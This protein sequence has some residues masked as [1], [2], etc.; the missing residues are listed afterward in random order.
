MKIAVTTASGGLGKTVIKEL[1]KKYKPEQIIGLAR[2]PEKARDL[3]I[4]IKPGDYNQRSDF[5]QGLKNVNTVLLVSA[6][7]PPDK[8]INM[9]RNVIEG[10][11]IAGVNKIIY[12]SIFGEAGKCSFDA[13]I[14]SNRQTENDIQTSGLKWIIGRNGLYIDADLVSVPEYKKTGKITNSA[15]SGKCSYTSRQ[16][17]AVAYTNLMTNDSFN[18]N[19]YNLC[20]NSITQEE[21]AQVFNQIFNL[22]LKYEPVSIESYFEDRIQEHG[23]FLGR[24]IGGIYQGIRLGVFDVPSDFEEIC[25]RKHLTILEMVKN[26][27]KY[28]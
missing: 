14:H 16:E 7:G 8:R 19:I 6:N 27:E 25:G 1:L 26:Y 10:A 3:G 20:G 22:D 15:G 9:H 21:L 17:L 28:N 12:T 11:K 4:E 18:Y 5:E 24:I 23:E 13:V 2:S